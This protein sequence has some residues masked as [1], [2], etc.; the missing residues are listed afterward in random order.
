[1]HVVVNGSDHQLSGDPSRTLLTVVR[2]EL[3][4][5]GTKPACGE[6]VCGACT[7]LLDGRPARACVTPI[8]D[9]DG[10]SVTTI[11]GLTPDTGLHPL[12]AAFVAERAFQC[13][14]CTPG[15][16]VEAAALLAATPDATAGDIA[17][18]L[19]GHVCRC[20][21]YARI[22]RAVQG[23]ASATV[24][25]TAGPPAP[26][27]D[28]IQTATGMPWDHLAPDER[29]WFAA[30]GNGLV[31]VLPPPEGRSRWRA[32]WSTPGGAWLHVGADGR[33]T[34]FSGKVELGQRIGPALA[35]IVAEAGGFRIDD[36]RIVLADT[37]VCPTDLGTFGS[38]STPDAGSMLR[39]AALQARDTLVSLAAERWEANPG[40]LV[41]IDGA[42]RSTDGAR[43]VAFGELVAGL[44]RVESVTDGSVPPA[45]PPQVE[46]PRR[47]T[48]DA[49]DLAIVTGR[50][51]FAADHRPNGLLIGREL[52]PPV[53]GATL[54]SLDT[55][56]VDRID[57]VT[58]VRED[59]LVAVAGPDAGTVDRAIAA[60]RAEWDLP[61]L[62]SERELDRHLRAHALDGDGWDGPFEHA[63]GDVDGALTAASATVDATWTTAFIAH[64]PL[65]THAAVA[66][67]HGD[68][69]TVRTSTQTPFSAREELA[70]A[71][72]VADDRVRVIVPP[73]GA[74]F[75]GKHGAGPGVAAALLA[76]ATGRPVRVRWTFAEEFV[77]GHLRPAAVIDVR[78]AVSDGRIA[79]VDQMN[80]SSGAQGIRPPYDIPHQRLRFQPAEAPLPQ[81]SYRALAATANTFARESAIDELAATTGVDPLAVRLAS[82]PDPRLAD[83]LRAAADAAGWPGTRAGPGVA[84][85]LA[86]GL[87]KDARV[88]TCAAVRI[89]P[90][91]TLHVERLVTAFVCGRIVDPDNLRSQI[92]GA[93]VMALGPALFEAIRF[94][95]D[96]IA[97]PSLRDYRVPR[98][99]DLPEI[100]V[101]LV[102]RPDLPSA[103]GGEVPLIAV[104]PAIA[105]AIARAGGPRLRSMPLVPDGRLPSV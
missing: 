2:D 54:R 58:L 13:G 24:A 73:V 27:D 56:A 85:G 98:F 82:G 88:A 20:G 70:E 96:G 37:D 28:G 11:E 35:A 77:R 53:A 80:V 90:D 69:V 36:V 97:N 25:E 6:G 43:S 74:G 9:A 46:T 15:M 44:R 39:V 93:T 75:G 59:D 100:D 21:M 87:E 41:A 8:G 52:Q 91:G 86:G 81:D 7:V 23:A 92:E 19:D 47:A 50:R 83:V 45:T 95:P 76:R 68:R 94:T 4:L 55:S 66:E 26:A 22:A 72:G 38:R 84:L 40:D 1:M 64:V 63:I 17:D 34:G 14:Y 16:I 18:G 102:D 103:G 104:A 60:M 101:V 3:G 42:V 30:L 71:L 105:N 48:A 67:W 10:R 57:G 12:Q 49:D 33:V 31:A 61:V 78:A 32:A 99:R 65:E 89:D 5:T 79:A 29:D 62:P 51:R